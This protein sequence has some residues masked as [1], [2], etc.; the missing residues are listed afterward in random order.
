MVPS[1]IA[2]YAPKITHNGMTSGVVTWSAR[3]GKSTNDARA[4]NSSPT[5]I[6]IVFWASLVP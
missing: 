2:A 5:M 1:A 4:A 3:T 6:P